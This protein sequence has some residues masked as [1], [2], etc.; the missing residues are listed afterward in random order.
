M[1]DPV[2]HFEIG[3]VDAARTRA[4]YTELFGWSVESESHGYGMVSTGSPHGIGG[5]IMQAPPG[6][7]AWL[8]VYVEVD[9]AEKALARAE[10]LGGRRVMGPAP[11]EGIG[12]VGMVTDPDG[13]VVGLLAPGPGTLP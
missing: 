8:T 7:P 3:G 9:D 4:F 5:G 12:D 11:V 6:A 1:G 2:V 10:E 13:N